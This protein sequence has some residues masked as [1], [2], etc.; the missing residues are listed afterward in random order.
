MNE[1]TLTI[2]GVKY[3]PSD[4]QLKLLE[5]FRQEHFA[6]VEKINADNPPTGALDGPATRLRRA[7]LDRYRNRVRDL[8]VNGT[9]SVPEEDAVLGARV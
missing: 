2:D 5:M 1:V 3:V 8:L 9:E 6:E 4:R 7:A